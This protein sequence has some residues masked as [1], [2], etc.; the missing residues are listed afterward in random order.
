MLNAH[1][2]VHHHCVTDKNIDVGTCICM[3]S[4]SWHQDIP[5]NFKQI[6]LIVL[7]VLLVHLVQLVHLG[8]E[9]LHLLHI[10]N[11]WHSSGA[12]K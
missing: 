10:S 3:R 5:E 9:I 1:Q 6:T 2:Y 11:S 4:R 7:I 8:Q 12:I